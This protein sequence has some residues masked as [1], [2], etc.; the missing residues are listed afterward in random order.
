M[1]RDVLTAWSRSFL[2]GLLEL[3]PEQVAPE[4]SFAS[5]GLDSAKSVQFVLAL[6]DLLGTELDPEIVERHDS[7]AAL[8]EHL[9]R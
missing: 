2:A 5:L 4:A 6:E 8:A 9:A 3:P 1:T 7:I